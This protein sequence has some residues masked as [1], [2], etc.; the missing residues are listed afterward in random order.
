VTDGTQ[1]TTATDGTSG[2]DSDQTP[3]SVAEVDAFWR[4]RFSNRDRA[5][6][7]EVAALKA[8]IEAMQKA[9]AASGASGD[10]NAAQLRALQEQLETERAIRTLS[11]KYPHAY[12]T[13]GDDVFRLP[14]EKVAAINAMGGERP[15][16]PAPRVDP[17]AAPRNAAALPAAKPME[18]KSVDELKAD[19]RA[20]APAY[21]QALSE[22]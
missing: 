22:R 5:H 8:Q 12:E 16:V 11:G 17:N 21:Q 14:E 18:E 7:A 10:P 1:N 6:N 2:T 9:P 20:L 15:V 13:L 4:N 3:G 19:L